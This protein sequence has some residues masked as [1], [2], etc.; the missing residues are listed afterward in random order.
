MDVPHF[1]FKR[2]VPL[3]LLIFKEFKKVGE[4][5]N[6]NVLKIFQREKMLISCN[7]DISFSRYT[8]FED[9]IVWLVNQ[10]MKMGMCFNYAT[11]S[12]NSL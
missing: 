9:T 4:R 10:E 12:C 2:N 7:N 6:R 5:E 11:N 1:L 8:T 3:N